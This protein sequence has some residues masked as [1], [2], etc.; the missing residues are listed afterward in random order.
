MRYGV[1]QQPLCC[2]ERTLVACLLIPLD[3][4][5]QGIFPSP[6]IPSVQL[7]RGIIVAY[8]AVLQ[9]A[10]H[11]AVFGAA[12]D[13][14]ELR[15]V[16]EVVHAYGSL[17][18][19]APELAAPQVLLLVLKA[20]YRDEGIHILGL[21]T[22]VDTVGITLSDVAAHGHRAHFLHGCLLGGRCS[23]PRH[24]CEGSGQ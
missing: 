24:E 4:A 11:E 16:C 5:Q 14:L 2:L 23:S 15:I 1:S 3:E 7:V 8:V 12:Y 22:M 6:H 9:L 18:P 17:H 19:F 10:G 13:F 20:E 21:Y